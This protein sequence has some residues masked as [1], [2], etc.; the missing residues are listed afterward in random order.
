MRR[1]ALNYS[2][3][4]TDALAWLALL[5][6]CLN[7]LL[8]VSDLSWACRAVR[9]DTNNYNIFH[10]SRVDLFY[11]CYNAQV[12]KGSPI[13]SSAA[14]GHG[15]SRETLLFDNQAYLYSVSR[16]HAHDG[17]D[18]FLHYLFLAAALFWWFPHN[19][20][21]VILVYSVCLNMILI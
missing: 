8:L 12:L 11:C 2:P 10:L 20:I 17:R 1:L 7:S 16:P 14:T 5:R 18:Y 4:V 15:G 6:F 21:S 9:T 19:I 3:I 13:L